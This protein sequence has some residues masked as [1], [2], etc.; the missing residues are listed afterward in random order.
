M[1]LPVYKIETYT[2][3]TLDHEITSDVLQYRFKTALT[4]QLGNFSFTLPGKKG[5]SKV[6]N[7]IARYDKVKF[8]A[9]H[10]TV[11]A[12]PLF[13]GRIESIQ[14]IGAGDRFARVFA[15]HD[16]G[17]AAA[18][19]MWHQN[20][21][22]GLTAHEAVDKWC[23]IC[24]FGKTEVAA[25]ATAVAI[26]STTSKLQSLFRDICDYAGTI[27]KDCYI[28]VNN[29]LVWKV[30]PLRTSGV[31]SL[32]EGENIKSYIYT[33]GDLIEVF[34]NIYVFGAQERVV[35]GTKTYSESLDIAPTDVPDTHK[36]WDEA[37]TNWAIDSST[38]LATLQLD[39][40]NRACTDWS[41]EGQ[42]PL[43][44]SPADEW[45]KMTRG[46]YGVSIKDTA[47][48]N[49]WYYW[50][51]DAACT[52]EYVETR[53]MT[54][55]SN[56]F[57]LEIAHADLP[58]DNSSKTFYAN[59]GP[60][61]ETADGTAH[62]KWIRVGSPSW[63]DLNYI[64]FLTHFTGPAS[65][66]L[67]VAVD[68]LYFSGMRWYAHA[69]N[70]GSQ[71]SYGVRD[72]VDVDDRL[73]SNDAAGTKSAALL[74]QRKDPIDQLDLTIR[75]FDPNILIGDQIPITLENEDLSIVN[76]NVIRVE[77]TMVQ[78]VGF[79]TVATLVTSDRVRS[80]SIVAQPNK[81]LRDLW[82]RLAS[83]SDTKILQTA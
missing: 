54:D 3:A 10:G 37:L 63:Y 71:T 30:R 75:P 77:Q 43:Y 49:F 57:R 39:G 18:R 34:N 70:G 8:Y 19:L 82:S 27:N 58:A 24:G 80:P 72:Y 50:F 38:D 16:L 79:D 78:D 69:L 56:Y 29:N 21:T 53:L 59:I 4:D 76:F 83:V 25:D 13:V 64:E 5:H 68:A 31:S 73:R 66:L 26:I 11:S 62:N 6:F 35:D 42:S 15:G 28:D 9:G 74:A 23:D 44:T 20:S 40:A 65:H 81:L 48:W 12:N 45:I 61:Y 47:R 22:V 52:L 36:A 17:E 32:L 2:G 14:N 67:R 46:P 55:A 51:G 7:D 1:P 33:K 41:I 60:T